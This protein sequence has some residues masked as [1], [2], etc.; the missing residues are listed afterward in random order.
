MSSKT[1]SANYFA[2]KDRVYGTCFGAAKVNMRKQRK[3]VKF[4]MGL[5]A[6]YGCVREPTEEHEFVIIP[7]SVQLL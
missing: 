6:V 1:E 3:S 4:L 5:R 2:V 7:L